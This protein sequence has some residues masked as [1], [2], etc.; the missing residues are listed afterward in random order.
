[1][2]HQGARDFYE[3]EAV[4][5][6]WSVRELSRQTGSLLFERLAKSRDKAGVL[7]L[8]SRGHEVTKPLDVLRDPLVME[9]LAARG[10]S[11]GNLEEAGK[12]AALAGSSSRSSSRR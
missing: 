4:K 7:R 10:A 3:I 8:A 12:Q 11:L 2:G 6:G 5:Q 1:M 9:F